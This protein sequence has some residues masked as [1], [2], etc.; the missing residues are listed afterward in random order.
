MSRYRL[1]KRIQTILIYTLL[2]IAVFVA[3]FP[4]YWV[5][6]TSIKYSRDHFVRPPILV[7]TDVTLDHYKFLFQLGVRSTIDIGPYLKNSFIIA[8]M[9]MVIVVVLSVPA[10]YAFARY[11]IGGDKTTFSLLIA[12]MLPPVVL[13][14]P[15]FLAY[16][17]LKLIDTHFGLVLSYATFNGPLAVWLLISFFE[18]FPAEIQDAALVDGCSEFESMLR[19]VLPLVAP[20]VAVVALFCFLTGWNDLIFVLALGG[21][22]TGTINLLMVNLLNA[23]SAELFG[24]AAGVVALGIIP[25]FLMTLFMQRYLVTGLSLGGVK[26]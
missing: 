20:G 3:M 7:P 12:R 9:N 19:V 10:A 6:T 8:F 23:P 26:G 4:F 2:I 1:A 13:I 22:D 21:K 15:L 18:D 11:R 24:P 14:I 25:P 17:S 5:L 16:R